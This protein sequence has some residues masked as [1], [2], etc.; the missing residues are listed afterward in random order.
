MKTTAL[1]RTPLRPIKAECFRHIRPL[2]PLRFGHRLRGTM[3]LEGQGRPVP[4]GTG[5]TATRVCGSRGSRSASATSR[6][7]ARWTWTSGAASSSPCSGPSGC[8]KTTTLRMVAGFEEPTEGRVLL[9]GEDVTGRPAFKRPT[10]TVFQ[11]YALF[12]HRS[13]EK[14]VAFGLERKKVD[15]AEIKRRVA[16]ELERVGLAG[17]GTA[18]ARAALGRPAAARRARARAREPPGRAAARR[19]ARRARPQAAQAAAGRAE[20][21]PARRRHHVHLRDP[22]PGGG[23]DDVRS[24]SR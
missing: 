6:R 12:P 7:S 8:G 21:D 11:S 15:K 13:V 4:A 2:R 1:P 19:A 17:R 5:A 9:D 24:R 14:N 22:R 16:E 23:A 10:N 18:P 3:S 20:A